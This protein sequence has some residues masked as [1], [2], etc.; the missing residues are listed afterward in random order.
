MFVLIFYT[1][2]QNVSLFFSDFFL[3]CSAIAYMGTVDDS[4]DYDRKV[5]LTHGLNTPHT[6]AVDLNIISTYISLA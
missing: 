4:D 3:L 1:V 2:G 5:M 6:H